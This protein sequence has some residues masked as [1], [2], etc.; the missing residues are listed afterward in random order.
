MRPTHWMRRALTRSLAAVAAITLT[1]GLAPAVALA[2]GAIG[3]TYVM[4]NQTTGNTVLIYDRAADGTITYSHSVATGGTGFGTGGDPLGSQGALT[5]GAGHLFAVNPGS[6]DVTMLEPKGGDLVAVDRVSSGGQQP[7]SVAVQGLLVYVLN[8]GGTP[9]ISGFFLDPFRNKLVP[10]PNSQR[11]L[12]GGATAAP[13]QISFGA[14]GRTLVVTE[15]G[16]NTIDTFRLSPFGYASAGISHASSG[17][18]PFGFS[19]TRR[20]Y[21]IVSEAKSGAASSY[22][23]E[24]NG[25][26]EPVSKSVSSGQK[27]PCWLVTSRDGRFAFTANAGSGT[28]SSYAIGADGT[29]TLGSA[30]DGVLAAPLDMALTA[31]GQ[32]LYVRE[33]TGLVSGF[34]VQSDGSLVAVNSAGGIPTGAQGIAA[35]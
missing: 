4:S 14:D 11:A 25:D 16:T 20:G 31:D 23:L 5:F 34:H 22:D 8:A 29:L 33:G 26:L 17:L 35:R 15:K 2:D 21:A 19:V 18:T 6:N 28:I 12:P 10:L 24:D 27:A 32:F 7:V 3:A 13:A 1:A 9:N 30:V